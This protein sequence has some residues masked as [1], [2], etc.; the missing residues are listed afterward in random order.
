MAVVYMRLPYKSGGPAASRE[1][2]E[3]ALSRQSCTQNVRSVRSAFSHHA[4]YDRD[5][6]VRAF[7]QRSDRKLARSSSEKTCGCSQAAKCPP[8]GSRL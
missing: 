5:R 6:A 7:P 4:R 3:V 8:L 2:V 1:G